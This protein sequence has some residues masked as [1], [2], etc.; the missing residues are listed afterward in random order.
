VSNATKTNT[1][2]KTTGTEKLAI[3]APRITPESM[4]KAQALNT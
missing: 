3:A 4:G 2:W 1:A